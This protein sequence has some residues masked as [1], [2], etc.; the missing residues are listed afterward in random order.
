MIITLKPTQMKYM[1]YIKRDMYYNNIQN[2]L[3]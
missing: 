2:T 1:E 3:I